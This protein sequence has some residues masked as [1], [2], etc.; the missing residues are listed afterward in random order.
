MLVLRLIA[1]LLPFLLIM[2]CPGEHI[3]YCGYAVHPM[4]IEQVGGKK[5][6]KSTE[7]E[8]SPDSKWL[9][10]AHLILL[11]RKD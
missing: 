8:D 1:L 3:D 10:Y 2:L 5:K 4:A 9:K 6:D 7:N 11:R